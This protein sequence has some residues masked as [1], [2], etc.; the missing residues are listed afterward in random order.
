MATLCMMAKAPVAGAVKTR[1]CP[2]LSPDR[3]AAIAAAFIEDSWAAMRRFDA[4]NSA[5]AFTGDRDGFP[6]AVADAVS[7]PQADGDLG[8]RI[9]AVIDEGLRRDPP[10]LVVGSD[11]P[12]L[13]LRLLRSA[14]TALDNHDAVLGPSDDG[15][16]YLI[17]C[18]RSLPGMLDD[19]P[20][21][22][23][24]T[25]EATSARLRELGLT[26]SHIE[27][28]FDVDDEHT[29]RRLANAIED[30]QVVAPATAKL[31]EQWSWR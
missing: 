19:L 17:G 28:W 20:W 5:L 23:S 16:Y 12:G 1:L 24:N 18:R 26:T 11:S 3:A 4:A 9:A 2:P 22:S 25:L 29:L 8:V 13:P 14:L 10:V 27:P 21:S 15:G 31:L 30:G 6:A 7:W